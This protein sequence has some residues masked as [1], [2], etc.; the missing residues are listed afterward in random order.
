LGAL[1]FVLLCDG[2]NPYVPNANVPNVTVPNLD[3][4]TCHGVESPYELNN[5]MLNCQIVD[6]IMCPTPKLSEY[7]IVNI[8]KC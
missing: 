3:M 2:V 8:I 5:N 6:V 1:I 4:S 7:Q